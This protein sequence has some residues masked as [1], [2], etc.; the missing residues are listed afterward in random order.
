MID[1]FSSVSDANTGGLNEQASQDFVRLAQA[2]A[3][4][5][6]QDTLA[7]LP[8]YRAAEVVRALNDPKKTAEIYQI[9]YSRY[10]TF[11]KAPE[12]LFML[13]FTYDE[14]LKNLTEAK[15]V[16]NKFLSLYPDHSFADDT[17]MLLKNLGKS[18][19]EIL[20]EL[21]KQAGMDANQE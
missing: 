21:E 17:E 20:K 14:D 6:P 3:D 7:A 2:F 18:D 19:E 11:S 13:G 4:K 5:Y 8:L 1:N 9:V 15:K 16:Y 10:P 12:A